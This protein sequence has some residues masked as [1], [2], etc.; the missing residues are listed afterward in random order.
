MSDLNIR[1]LHE[2]LL[3]SGI[4]FQPGLSDLEVKDIEYRHS[5]KFPPDLRAFLQHAM[6]VSRGFPNW[7]DGSEAELQDLVDWPLEGILFDVENN[8]FWFPAWGGRPEKLELAVSLAAVQVLTA[9]R[10]IPVY[11]RRYIPC[12]P[13]AAGNPVFS[14]YQSDILRYRSSLGSYLAAEFGFVPPGCPASC[15]RRIRFWD[16]LMSFNKEAEQVAMR[17]A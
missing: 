5:F 11:S 4:A 17:S 12:E 8:D 3:G 6:P 7:R 2:R 13:L 10:L 9:P 14:L 15:P 1:E 16:E